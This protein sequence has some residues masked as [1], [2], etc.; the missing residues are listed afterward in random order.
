MISKKA[1][2]SGTVNIG[3]LKISCFVTEDGERFISGRSMTAAIG[4]KGRGQ[5]MA[6]ISGNTTLKPYLSKGLALAISEPIEIT[7]RTPK[8]VHGYKAEILA[9]LCDTIL[10]ARN[11]GALTTQQEQ[12]YG[13]FAETL[14]RGFARLGIVALIDE[15]TGYQDKRDKDALQQ[16][17]TKF[18]SDEQRKWA[19]TFPDEFWHKLIKVKGYPSYMALKRP[20]FVGHWV[21]SIVYDRIAPGISSKL[22]A[23]NP[24]RDNGN[25]NHKHHQH[26]TDDHG[27]PE[28][29][30]HLSK[31]MVLMDASAN[32]RE[33]ERLLNRSLP[34][35]G[36]T[37][38]LPFDGP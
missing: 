28:L 8:P 13:L 38:D 4:M 10:E 22:K 15:A 3:D 6:R 33:F 32:N 29:R 34:K 27:L 25:R 18:L 35:Y 1:L 19:K 2:Y 20:S 16:I 11:N 7:G 17:L 24:R 5:G 36:D 21:N 14:V 37:I 30:E 9:D 12:R 23:L 26:F 31:V